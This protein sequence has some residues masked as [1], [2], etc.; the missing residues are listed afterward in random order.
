ML[1]APASGQGKTLV[2]AAVARRHRHA[3]RKVR[4]FKCGPDLLD[5]MIFEQASGAPVHQVDLFMCGEEQCRALLHAAAREADL[6]LV[7]EGMGLFDGDPSAADLA[8]RFDLPV[9]AVID[10]SATAQTFGALVHGLSH[11]RKDVNLAAAL[12]I[13]WRSSRSHRRYTFAARYH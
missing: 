7:E 1:S 8:A 2:T 6:I 3:G 13:R 10:G 4:V 11:Y 9:L 5:P 12:A